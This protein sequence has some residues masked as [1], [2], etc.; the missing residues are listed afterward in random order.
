MILESILQFFWKLFLQIKY[1]S[2]E[3]RA[4]AIGRKITFEKRVKIERGSNIFSEK[5]GRYTYIGRNC[6]I[7]KSTKIIGRF[8]SI[9]NGVTLGVGNHPIDWVSTHAIAFNKK[10]GFVKTNN[11]LNSSKKDCKIGNDVWIGTNAI[12]IAGVTVGDGAIIGANAFVNKDVEPYSIVVGTPAKHIRY[13]FDQ[14]TVKKLLEIK[15]WNWDDLQ[16][17]ECITIMKSPDKFINSAL[18][19]N[20]R[21]NS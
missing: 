13:R 10:Y 9:A 4:N 7:D 18:K 17:Q 11:F 6:F 5:I 15:W 21:K 14:E 3:I 19:K 20:N 1:P 16:I 2:C 8:C 12:I